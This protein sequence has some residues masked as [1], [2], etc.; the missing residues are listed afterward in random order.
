MYLFSWQNGRKCGFTIHIVLKDRQ[1]IVKI[2]NMFA[3]HT[4]HTL[5]LCGGSQ[6]KR[7]TCDRQTELPIGIYLY[8][9]HYTGYSIDNNIN[10]KIYQM[11]TAN[12]HEYW[13]FEK[14]NS[15]AILWI[16][17]RERERESELNVWIF[18]CNVNYIHLDLEG[19]SLN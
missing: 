1:A 6:Q 12:T 15:H 14:W 10:R 11:Y 13:I 19:L 5:Y 2:N 17:Y 16:A 7:A 3:Q 9:I 4:S 18:D 8:I